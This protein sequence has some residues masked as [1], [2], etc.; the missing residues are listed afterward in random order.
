MNCALCNNAF[1][2]GVQCSS[3]MKYL[4]FACAGITESGYR[5]L[6]VDRRAAWKC[7]QCRSSLI[8]PPQQPPT[9]IDSAPSTSSLDI[10]L[11]EIRD[12]KKQLSSLPTLVDDVKSIKN[13]IVDLKNSCEF[14]SATLNEQGARLTKVEKKL[15]DLQTTQDAVCS[16]PNELKAIKK[17]FDAR[18]QRSRLNNVE[19]KGIPFNKAENLFTIV[20]QLTK[21]VDYG[22]PKSQINYVTRIPTYNPKEK[23]IIISFINRYIKEDFVAAARSKKISACDLGFGENTQRIFVND[24]LTP[25]NKKLLTKTKSIAKDKNYSY[26]WVKFGKI[27]VR[28]NDTSNMVIISTENDLNKI[29]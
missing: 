27:H 3:C 25:M 21:T 5:K 8:N 23:S 29:A 13:E 9:P 18:D 11:S 24:H 20:E 6:G 28:K 16:I 7:S 17:D 12:L 22:F 26:V 15:N 2:D 14:N 4:D 10:I 19:I 1:N